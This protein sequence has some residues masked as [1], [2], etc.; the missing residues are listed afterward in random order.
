MQILLNSYNKHFPPWIVTCAPSRALVC[1][2]WTTTGLVSLAGCSPPA[3]VTVMRTAWWTAVTGKTWRWRRRMNWAA[4][5]S[6]TPHTGTLTLEGW[7]TVSICWDLALCPYLVSEFKTFFSSPPAV[8]L[9]PNFIVLDKLTVWFH[10]PC[11]IID[12]KLAAQ[13]L[14]STSRVSVDT[15]TQ[16]LHES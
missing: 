4:G 7:S 14:R 12:H 2:M 16:V 15:T 11:T 3:V 6:L 9:L 10:T 13:R 5:A 1:T 8:W